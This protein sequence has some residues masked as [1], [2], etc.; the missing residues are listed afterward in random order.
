M[1]RRA[2]PGPNGWPLCCALVHGK[3]AVQRVERP[4]E[5]MRVLGGLRQ[6]SAF[7]LIT[8][9]T[10]EERK[11][12]LQWNNN[13]EMFN[14]V[15]RQDRQRK[16]DRDSFARSIQR[17]MQEELGLRSPKDYRILREL[18]PLQK[19][20]FSRREFVFKE[21]EFHLFH[22]EFLPRHP[23]TAEEFERFADPPGS[24]GENLLVARAEIERLR[25][26]DGR[27][28]SETT[29]MILQDLG[30]IDT[31]Y[32]RRCSLTTLEI[33]WPESE[34][35]QGQPG[36]CPTAGYAGQSTHTAAWWKM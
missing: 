30:E 32:R 21:Y 20:Q 3:Q 1:S 10:G 16:G 33:R 27:P 2:R 36:P 8:I 29:R 7:A 5:I 17:K 31:M 12:L 19:R 11:Y 15:G 25:T 24:P 26:N 18:K 9:G 35:F 4:Y 23:H 13:W 34:R 14:L 28:I 22:I 6:R